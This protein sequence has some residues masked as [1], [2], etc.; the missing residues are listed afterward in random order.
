MNRCIYEQE[1]AKD[2]MA[3]LQSGNKIWDWL[4]TSLKLVRTPLNNLLRGF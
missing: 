4:R 2:A 3:G 1:T